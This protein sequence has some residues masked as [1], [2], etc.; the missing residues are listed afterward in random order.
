MDMISRRCY[1]SMYSTVT[2][3]H[4]DT[5]LIQMSYLRDFNMRRWNIHFT[6][7][8]IRRSFG[9]IGTG[10]LFGQ[11]IKHCQKKNSET[12]ISTHHG[13]MLFRTALQLYRCNTFASLASS[14]G[15]MQHQLPV[16]EAMLEAQS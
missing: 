15:R 1:S 2:H 5:K 6:R 14:D 8:C 10:W 16:L 3:G 12:T 4:H 7:L 13:T 11:I 9:N